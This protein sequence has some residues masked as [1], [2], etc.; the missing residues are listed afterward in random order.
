MAVNHG[1]VPRG[2]MATPRSQF[3]EGR[4]GRLFRNLNAFEPDEADLIELADTV[5]EKAFDVERG[6]PK[7]P[8]PSNIADPINGL[9][10]G[11]TYLGQFLDHDLTFDPVSQLDRINDPDALRDFRTPRFDLDNVYGGGPD[12]DVFLYDAQ[13]RKHLLPK[14]PQANDLQRN[15]QGTAIIG[16][17]RN[18]ENAIVANL[19]LAFIKYHNSVVDELKT[20]DDFNTASQIVRFHYQWLVVHDF[21]ARVVGEDLVNSILIPVKDPGTGTVTQ[22]TGDLRFFQPHNRPFMPVEFS[23]AAYRFGHSMVRFNYTLN[24]LTDPDDTP[25]AKELPIFDTTTDIDLRGGRP[26]DLI[27]KIPPKDNIPDRH[28]AWFRF[29]SFNGKDDVKLQPA[30]TIDTQISAGLGH[31]APSVGAA[32]T[33][34]TSLAARNLLRGR[35]LGLPNGQDVAHAMGIPENL[36]ISTSNTDFPFTIGTGYA[37]DGSVPEIT[38]AEKNRLVT[39]FGDRT[40]L[41]Y[42]ILK[43]AE[44]IQKG[45]MLGPV[46]GRIVAEVFIGLLLNDPQSYLVA[47]P[48]FQPKAG[49]FGAVQDG[50]FGIADLIEHAVGA[51][52]ND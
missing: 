30:R 13:D 17:P 47:Q 9:S 11:F 14:D 40:P 34:P 52:T 8:R 21:L 35:A 7:N 32:P 16:D 39:L 49:H 15:A 24:R 28:V 1:A 22:W 3:H 41:W 29:L 48:N 5:I 18:D 45:Q 12:Q 25:G 38:D 42:Y 19:H 51:R 46:G 2:L 33:G 43:E 31:M 37:G 6:D 10:S 50:Q 20:S 36:I 23:A 27:E 26:L 44:L 4:F